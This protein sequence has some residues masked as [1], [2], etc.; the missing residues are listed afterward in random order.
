MTETRIKISSV[1][2]GQLPSFVR[3]EF[4]LVSEFLS[5]YYLSLEYQSG[6][7]DLLQNIDQYVKVDQLTNLTELTSLSSDISFADSTIQ[8]SSTSGF[9][10]S[11][12]LLLI[13]DEIITYTSKDGNNFYGCIRGFNGVTSYQNPTITDQLIFSESSSADHLSNAEV[14]NLSILFLKEFLNKVKRQITPGF[15]GRELYSGLNE[16]L[17]I[18]Q[19]IDFY[20]SKGTDSS[21]KI[22]FNALYGQNVEVIKPRDFLIEP[23]N[24]QYR[25][26]KDLVVEI[27]SGDPSLLEGK[28]LYQDSDGFFP[29]ANGTITSASKILRGAK[30]Y[31][32]ISLDYDYDKDINVTGTVLGTFSIHPKTNLTVQ[33]LSGSDTLEVDTTI[34]FPPS[35]ELIVKLSD[36]VSL[37]IFYS[38]KT[39]NQFLGCTGITSNIE[40]NQEIAYNTFAYAYAS[41]NNGE[42]IKV[43]ITGVLSD[44]VFPT[45][46]KYYENGDVIQIKTLG[47]YLTD[48]KSNSWFLNIPARYDVEQIQLLDSS[49]FIIS[50]SRDSFDES[51]DL[52]NSICFL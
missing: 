36:E 16:S 27:L 12:G 30:E 21:F 11:Y 41:N 38:D 17:F 19:S 9:P 39:I 42:L 49:D 18:K 6:A 1:V 15:D 13:D 45:K 20:S 2:E 33:A 46:N 37:S 48:Y 32:T 50:V 10:D 22:L 3:E 4:P 51:N 34:G 23:S 14:K 52:K 25:I 35:G 7:T 28:T 47:A 8:V 44:I 26:T 43:R 24:A 31:Y 29:K 5:Q 40:T